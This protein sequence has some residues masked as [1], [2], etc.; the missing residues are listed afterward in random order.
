MWKRILTAQRPSYTKL[1]FVPTSSSSS[2]MVF[3][4]N[5]WMD[6]QQKGE[7]VLLLLPAKMSTLILLFRFWLPFPTETTKILCAQIEN[8]ERKRVWYWDRRRAH[9][10]T[11]KE[12]SLSIHG[13]PTCRHWDDSAGKIQVSLLL[14]L[15]LENHQVDFR[16]I[17]Q[18][19]HRGALLFFPQVC[20]APSE[21]P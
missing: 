12:K 21:R 3:P 7:A 1:V 2:S 14:L 17:Q 10:H 9:G 20:G 11:R 4:Q 18:T 6:K 19:R 13:H 15:L 8:K 16:S 5:Y